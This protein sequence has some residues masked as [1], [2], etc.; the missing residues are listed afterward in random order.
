M[1][2][3]NLRQSFQKMDGNQTQKVRDAYY[4]AVCGL[5][6]LVTALEANDE[7]L[8]EHYLACQALEVM[9]KSEIGKVL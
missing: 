9:N 4:D 2:A 8:G 5:Q 3:D 6:N 7:L 1:S